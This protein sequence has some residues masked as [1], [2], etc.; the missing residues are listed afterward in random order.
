MKI[1]GAVLA[2]GASRRFGSD[3]ALALY[4]GRPL[5]EHAILSLAA[6][7]GT[8]VIA[9]R[10]HP[11]M[12]AVADRP[13]AGMGPLSGLAGALAY[14]RDQ[15]F[16]A[17]LSCGVDSLG[18]PDDLIE[19][20][21][22][23]PAHVGTQPVIGLWPVGTLAVLDALLAECPKGPSMRAFADRIAARAIA[24]DRAPGNINT[25]EDLAAMP[26]KPRS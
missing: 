26:D 21:S 12:P 6:L 20:L 3:K 1:L 14:A 25:P 8:V 19:R 7:C 9:G 23:A 22:P 18:L 4:D 5:I 16:E 15:G 17:V 2:G 13:Q 10:D 24:L 11:G